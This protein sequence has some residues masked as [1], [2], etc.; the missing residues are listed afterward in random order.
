[1][2]VVTFDCAVAREVGGREV[3]TDGQV[4]QFSSQIFQHTKHA[5]AFTIQISP[6]SLAPWEK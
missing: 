1:L 5:G 6:P 3:V 2:F 4:A